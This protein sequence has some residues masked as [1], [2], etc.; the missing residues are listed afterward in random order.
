M[1]VFSREE[2]QTLS[3]ETLVCVAAFT[4]KHAE[5]VSRGQSARKLCL[6]NSC[7]S[8]VTVCESVC[9]CILSFKKS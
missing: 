3:Q 5:R 7:L 8:L 2:M 6:V 9:I 4:M 1:S